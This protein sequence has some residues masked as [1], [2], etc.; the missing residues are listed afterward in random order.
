MRPSH[1]AVC[2]FI[3]CLTLAACGV[4]S[5]ATICVVPGGGF[6][7]K[8]T[9][10]AAV[11]AASSGDVIEVAQG[12]YNEQVTITKTLSL[13]AVPFAQPVINA[14]GHSNGIFI[15]GMATAPLPGVTSVIV[16]GFKVENANY[17]GI[18][19]ANA[20]DVILLDNHV[21]NNNKKLEP[22][23]AMCPGIA[24]FETNEAMDCGEG[25]HLMATDHAQVLRNL[26][27]NN[28]G[29]DSDYIRDWAQHEQ[30][31]EGQQ[32]SRQSVCLRDY[33]G[34][35]SSCECFGADCRAAVSDLA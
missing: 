31:G 25:I 21:L 28:S 26:I 27:E 35:A 22:S 33:D 6:G 17:E 8:A 19:V 1:F 12:T 24:G 5:A 20:S 13:V 16:Q 3:C 32:R 23:A 15:N 10:S 30:P 34:W 11:A 14:L 9:I 2:R 7:C 4:S 29:G 18:L